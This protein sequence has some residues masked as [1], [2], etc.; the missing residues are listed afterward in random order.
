MHDREID[1]N[2]GSP[3]DEGVTSTDNP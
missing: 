3:R 1:R 2:T